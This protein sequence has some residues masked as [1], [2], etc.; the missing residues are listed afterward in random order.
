MWLVI[1]LNRIVR[2]RDSSLLGSGNEWGGNE[3]SAGVSRCLPHSR[4][5]C[6]K[7]MILFRPS[8]RVSNSKLVLIDHA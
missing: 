3:W 6:L 7:H 5:E 8:Y 1:A 4:V 2:S